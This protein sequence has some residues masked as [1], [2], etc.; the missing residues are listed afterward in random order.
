[1]AMKLD[2]SNF[3]SVI[4]GSTPVLVDFWATWCGPCRMMAPVVEELAGKLEGKAVVGKVDVDEE[5]DIAQRYGIMSI[6]TFMV[7]K[8]GKMVDHLVGA[9]PAASLE[10]MIRKHL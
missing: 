5:G 3:D 8:N 4:G 9:V 7:F 2:A 6:P 1:M 10:G